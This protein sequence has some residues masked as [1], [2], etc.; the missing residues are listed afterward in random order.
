[1]TGGTAEGDLT[2]RVIQERWHSAF[3]SNPLT[4]KTV[5]YTQTDKITIVRAA[6]GAPPAETYVV[7]GSPPTPVTSST[8]GDP[9]CQH[10]DP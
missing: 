1:M 2:K 9:V 7:P 6:P 4:G 10:G 8:T 3:W 5:P